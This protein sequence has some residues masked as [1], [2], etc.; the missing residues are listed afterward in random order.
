MAIDVDELFSKMFT[1]GAN[2]FG[3]GWNEVQKYAKVEFKTIAQRMDDIGEA[4]INNEFDL[5]TGKML[6]AMQINLAAAAIAGATTLVLLA[7][8]AAIN[9]V[10]DVIRDFVNA[11]LGF[12]LV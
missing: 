11:A 9:A 2:A 12:A 10:L 6:L 3:E 1:S 8:E 7:V 5:A 4:L